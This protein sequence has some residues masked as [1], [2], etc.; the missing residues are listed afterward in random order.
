MLLSWQRNRVFQESERQVVRFSQKRK[1]NGNPVCHETAENTDDPKV[2]IDSEIW[3][4]LVNIMPFITLLLLTILI[5][6]C[7]NAMMG[8]HIFLQKN[9]CFAGSDSAWIVLSGIR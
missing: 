6:Y 5:P 9:T 7:L 1:P 4:I 2:V 3:Q 8:P